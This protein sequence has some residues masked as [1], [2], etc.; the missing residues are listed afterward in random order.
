M[1]ETPTPHRETW[2]WLWLD[3]TF[4]AFILAG[5][6]YMV[7]VWRGAQAPP[8]APRVQIEDGASVGRFDPA[9]VSAFLSWHGLAA[10]RP[11]L[12][13][14]EA[15]LARRVEEVLVGISQDGTAASF[16][17]AGQVFDFLKRP[18]VARDC[19]R[20][21]GSMDSADHRWPHYL[22]RLALAAGDF[23]EAESQFLH[24]IELRP[25]FAASHAQLGRVYVE[26]D[27]LSDAV[28]ALQ[29]AV[30][31]APANAF[32]HVLLA[33]IAMRQEQYDKA[34]R[35]G[36][37][38]LQRDPDHGQAHAI[39]GQAYAH[40]ANRELAVAHAQRAAGV[41]PEMAH[42]GD[43]LINELLEVSGSTTWLT[44]LAQTQHARGEWPALITTLESLMHRE[45]K[46]IDHKLDLAE[47]YVAARR[48]DD[49]NAVAE[50]ALASSRETPRCYQVLSVIALHQRDF[51]RAL[52]NADEAIELDNEY[53]AAHKSRAAALAGLGRLNEAVQSAE[54]A[55]RLSPQD[56]EIRG[57]VDF[58]QKQQ[59]NR[60]SGG[61]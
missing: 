32:G 13:E 45:P 18:A 30:E 6:L 61:S 26:A 33:R 31:K 42:V 34:I 43:P 16:G 7:W 2:R 56:V 27:K 24:A 15:G 37:D 35:H 4:A 3:Y 23:D 14:L 5:A 54:T 48:L 49:A 21:A 40:T 28:A 51:P 8:V 11:P 52:S 46:K 58:L 44:I 39:L 9:A 60:Q 53:A 55:A 57:L 59:A 41:R 17:R 22:G 38:A 20:R 25:S 47:A 12:S 19:Y 10:P 36:L 50:T 1:S 29:L